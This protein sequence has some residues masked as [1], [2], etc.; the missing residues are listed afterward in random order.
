MAV[1]W[2]A[3]A[4]LKYAAGVSVYQIAKWYGVQWTTVAFAVDHRGH[5]QRHRDRLREHRLKVKEKRHV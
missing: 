2:H 5:R 4:K 3:D 1:S